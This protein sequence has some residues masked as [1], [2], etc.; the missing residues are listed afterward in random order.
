M[1]GLNIYNTSLFSAVLLELTSGEIRV[2]TVELR[3]GPVGGMKVTELQDF[4]GVLDSGSW[5]DRCHVRPGTLRIKSHR[6]RVLRIRFH[7][8]NF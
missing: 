2:E 8:V 4:V 5:Y 1:A 3:S 7:D 6:I